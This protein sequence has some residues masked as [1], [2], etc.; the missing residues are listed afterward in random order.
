MGVTV[1]ASRD[2]NPYIANPT[3]ADKNIEVLGPQRQH[4]KSE[5]NQTRHGDTGRQYHS[6]SSK[7]FLDLMTV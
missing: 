3:P 2:T 4:A 1:L 5:D 6:C 7:T